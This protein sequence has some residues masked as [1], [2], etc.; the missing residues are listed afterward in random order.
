LTLLDDDA[1]AMRSS[2]ALV[3]NAL[4]VSAHPFQ[5]L[6]RLRTEWVTDRLF[7]ATRKQVSKY[8]NLFSLNNLTKWAIFG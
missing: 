1:Q 8:R 2:Q 6:D 5:F 7:H 4:F 3:A